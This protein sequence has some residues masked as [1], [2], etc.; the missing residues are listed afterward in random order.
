MPHG[1][2]TRQICSRKTHLQE[3][4]APDPQ[5][6]TWRKTHPGLFALTVLR[7]ASDIWMDT[8]VCNESIKQIVWISDGRK[9]LPSMQELFANKY[10]VFEP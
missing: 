7:S 5:I 2:G 9:G 1:G 8:N 6:P 4:T 3:P 10:L